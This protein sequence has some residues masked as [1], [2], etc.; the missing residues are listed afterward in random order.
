MNLSN[1][2]IAQKIAILI[3]S[4]PDKRHIVW[5]DALQKSK[6]AG[7]DTD[8]ENFTFAD[9]SIDHIEGEGA[10]RVVYK[11]IGDVPLVDVPCPCG[12]PTC[13]L[14]KYEDE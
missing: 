5:E 8:A 6:D 13:W 3:T 9:L 14:I 4:P 10:C 1:A 11:R 12:D 7:I 2:T